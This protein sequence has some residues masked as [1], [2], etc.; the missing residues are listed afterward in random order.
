MKIEKALI[1]IEEKALFELGLL[2]VEHFN[3]HIKKIYSDFDSQLCDNC[4]HY[5][6]YN[7]SSGICILRDVG[8][9]ND[10]SCKKWSCKDENNT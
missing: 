6:E 7:E 8:V 1:S 2:N 4:K 10:L 5:D 3:N 9:D